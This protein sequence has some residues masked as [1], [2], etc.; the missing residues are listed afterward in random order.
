MHSPNSTPV[1]IKRVIMHMKDPEKVKI[2]FRNNIGSFCAWG[3]FLV[4]ITFVYLH[5]SDGDFSF[6]MTLSSLLSMFSFAMVVYVI[7]SSKS[8]KGVS[9]IMYECYLIVFFFRLCSII[10]FEGYLPFDRSGDWLYQT[11]EGI[12]F[13]LC[14]IVV[15]MCR[16][17]YITTYSP[18]ADTLSRSLLIIPTILLSLLFHPSLNAFAPADISWT[19]ALYLESISSLPQLF[20]FQREKKVEPFTTHFLAGQALSRVGVC[21]CVCMSVFLCV[22]IHICV[23]VYIYVYVCVFCVCVCV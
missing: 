14:G 9:L 13:I 19:F 5:L 10:P 17:R 12:T 23:C 15:Y 21:V 18:S 3:A 8:V 11:V 16:I 4:I 20:L 1:N 6:L 22:Y 2:F 7:E